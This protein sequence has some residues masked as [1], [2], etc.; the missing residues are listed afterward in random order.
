MTARILDLD[1]LMVNVPDAEAAGQTF[2]RLGFTVTPKSVMPGLANRLICFAD[3]DPDHGIC[4]YIELM[5]MTDPAIA[6]PPMPDLLARAHGP[7]STV[8]AVD[9]AEAV[10]ARLSDQGLGVGPVLHLQR[11]WHLPGGEVISPAF[12]VAIP[13]LEQRPFYWNYCQHKTAGHYVR[14]DFTGH[15]NAIARLDAVLAVHE[16]PAEAAAPYAVDWQVKPAGEDPVAVAPGRV[17]L[18]IHT[19]AA[20]AKRFGGPAPAPGLCGI[21][22]RSRDLQ[23]SAAAMPE[24]VME[25]GRLLLAPEHAAGT[26]IEIVGPDA[27]G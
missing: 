23:A 16:A 15:R 11:D 18:E 1:H 5:G 17:A 19:P 4:N 14:P 27:P 12:A 26:L 21:R 8:M 25:D 2:E 13:A 22:L 6:P 7:I 10:T 3:A 24:A 9:D 20:F